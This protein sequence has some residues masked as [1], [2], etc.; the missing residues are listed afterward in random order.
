M[1]QRKTI[2]LSPAAGKTAAKELA[3]A[4]A[5]KKTTGKQPAWTQTFAASGGK[6]GGKIDR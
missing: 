1:T 3:A 4:L 5:G 2:Q 6:P